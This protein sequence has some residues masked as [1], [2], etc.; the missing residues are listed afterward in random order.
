VPVGLI[1]NEILANAISYGF[2]ANEGGKI[3]LHL[4]EAKGQVTLLIKDNGEGFP[5]DIN[6]ESAE[7]TGLLIVRTL[8][9]QLD[10]KVTFNNDNGASFKL[11]FQKSNASGAASSNL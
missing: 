8:V 6:Y 1:V 7:S 11:R 2:N 5:V 4:S 3:V 9:E 10:G